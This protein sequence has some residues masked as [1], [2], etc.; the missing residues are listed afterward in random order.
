MGI[1][2]HLNIRSRI[3]IL[4][5]LP[6]LIIGLFSLNQY[7]TAK[8]EQLIFENL[9]FVMALSYEAGK[10]MDQVQNERDLS[11]GFLAKENN[12]VGPL[13]EYFGS[14]GNEFESSLKQSR[15][16]VDTQLG[17]FNQYIQNH[18]TEIALVPEVAEELTSL[19]NSIEAML[20]ARSLVDQYIIKDGNKWVLVTYDA[21]SQRFY[22]L[23]EAIVRIASNNRELSL[24]SNAYNALVNLGE[25]YSVE[26]G[27]VLRAIYMKNLDYNLYA[28]E[29]TTRQELS[30]AVER[31]NAFASRALRIEFRQQHL[32]SELYKK[33]NSSWIKFRGSAGK[34]LDL[35]ANQWY[36]DSSQNI[37]SLNDF[38]RDL[39]KRIETKADELYDQAVSRVWVSL[40]III[41][42]VL[43]MAVFSFVIIRSIVKPLKNM[44]KELSYVA[45]NKDLVYP[46]T[47]TGTDELSEVASAFQL[48]LSSFNKTLAGV[49][50]V[51]AKMIKLTENV[52]NSMTII[53]TRAN[54]QNKNTDGVSVAMN[55]MTASVKEVSNSAIYTS[56]AVLRLFEMS[57][58][59]A[60]GATTS[61]EIMETLTGELDTATL[62]VEQLNTE[63]NAIGDV[64][65]VIQGIAEQTNLLALNAAIEA[66]RA[67]EQGRGFAVVADE[68]R[69]LASR[70]Q[71][72]TGH[73]K[74]QIEALQKGTH[75]VTS[76]MEQLKAQG[77]KAVDVVVE[78][79]GAFS[80]LH[81]ELDDIAKMSTQI[82]TAAEEQTVVSD[83][84]NKQI[85]EIK[86]DSEEMSHHVQ[87][88]QMASQELNETSEVLD[89]Y[90]DEFKC[91]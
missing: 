21:T 78:S 53:Q 51:E 2:S 20:E 26:R 24:L 73:I 69:S 81:Q 57:D 77:I 87:Q 18:Q 4:A 63:S 75:T 3:I 43:F 89:S 31:F 64:I 19:K 66:A 16:A 35:D 58:K 32:E 50:D 46:V 15:Q 10:L 36:R 88:T 14:Q 49:R 59:S 71:E 28:R 40:A 70:T 61:K 91:G 45:K 7:R 1:L 27:V 90:I 5:V 48:L 6:M 11:N 74:H 13:G 86:E 84:I 9:K 33:V 44:V 65:N 60:K 23:F 17:L 72:S 54:N 41:G 38:K 76:N 80:V 39:A 62:L 55:E 47:V 34:K 83:D 79:L 56:D 12:F 37:D 52:S 85:H 67:G 8:K 42:G 30:N 82:A 68:V 25:R 29:K 22:K